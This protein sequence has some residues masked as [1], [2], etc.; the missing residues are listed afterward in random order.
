MKLVVENLDAYRG[1]ELIFTDVNFCVDGGNALIVA[2]PN[3]VGKSTLL[4]VLAG[5]LPYSSPSAN[6]VAKIG[7]ESREQEYSD[8]PLAEI[9]HYLG[10]ENAMKPALSVEENLDFWQQHFDNPAMPIDDALEEVG[11]PGIGHIPFG[12]L[13]TGQRRRVAICR[14]LINA[15]PLWLLDE[16]TSGLDKSSEQRLAG[17]MEDHLADGGMIVAATHLPLGLKNCQTL[18][19]K[20]QNF[21]AQGTLA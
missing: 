21:T 5:L 20:Q 6:S 10:H 11:L 18:T 3:G 15:R 1:E 19:F 8:R 7:L 13:S 12:H 9:C 14:L 2:G 17:I 4:K 16:P